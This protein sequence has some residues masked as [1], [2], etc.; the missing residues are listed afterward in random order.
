[1][2]RSPTDL[3]HPLRP[4]G[5]AA[6]KA[7]QKQSRIAQRLGVSR[8]TVSRWNRLLL[9][10]GDKGVQRGAGRPPSIDRTALK[11]F[12]ESLK[13]QVQH[14]DPSTP[15]CWS[16]AWVAARIAVRFGVTYDPSYVWRL[17]HQLGHQWPKPGR[18]PG[19]PK[20]SGGDDLTLTVRTGHRDSQGQ[21]GRGQ[22]TMT[23]SSDT[24][25]RPE[26][27]QLCNR[28][29]LSEE[30]RAR[31]AACRREEQE[32]LVQAAAKVQ[33]DENL[34]RL[35]LRGAEAEWLHAEL[36][37]LQ[38]AVVTF[39]AELRKKQHG[40]AFQL[41]SLRRSNVHL[42]REV[43][44]LEAELTRIRGFNRPKGRR[45]PPLQKPRTRKRQDFITKLIT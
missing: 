45:Y 30:T 41:D 24:G 29:R 13:R 33:T 38:E 43:D 8:Q 36:Q 44:A 22:D 11:A 17:L 18:P 12:I 26:L 9:T 10:Q 37:Q 6:L 34:Q 14:P 19:Q 20:E 39:N 3:G 1:M 28:H 35:V 23:A 42:A 27:T 2:K 4:Q 31:F 7:G 5:I 40:I 25:L 15:A 16:T 32:Q 21:K